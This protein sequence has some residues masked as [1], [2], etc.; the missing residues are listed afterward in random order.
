VASFLI[1]GAWNIVW[2]V[3]V[4]IFGPRGRCLAVGLCSALARLGSFGGGLAVSSCLF[5]SW[6]TDVAVLLL[7]LAA[8]LN[9]VLLDETGNTGLV[10]ATK[11]KKK[12]RA[13]DSHQDESQLS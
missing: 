4:Q 13:V 9:L 6:P 5:S 7:V 12:F 11:V 8:A 10:E 3:S 2:L 1:T